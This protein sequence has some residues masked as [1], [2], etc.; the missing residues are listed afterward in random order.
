MTSIIGDHINLKLYG[1]RTKLNNPIAV[2]EIPSSFNHKDMVEKTNSKGNPLEKPRHN[3][4][5][6]LRLEYTF[7]ALIQL[8]IYRLF[9]VNVKEK[10]IFP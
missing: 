6:I 9:L 7:N 5:N 4:A 1:V 2:L 8:F 10:P 3:I